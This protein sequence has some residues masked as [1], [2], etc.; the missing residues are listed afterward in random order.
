MFSFLQMSPGQCRSA[1]KSLCFN[2][3]RANHSFH[4]RAIPLQR[5]DLEQAVDELF[6]TVLKPDVGQTVLVGYGVVGHAAEAEDQRTDDTRPVFAR[7]AVDEDWGRAL[8]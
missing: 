8:F 6:A 4:S 2:P 7:R 3:P 5:W 1:Q